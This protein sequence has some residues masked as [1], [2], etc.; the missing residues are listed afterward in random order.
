MYVLTFYMCVTIHSV[1]VTSKNP[2]EFWF[3]L[4]NSPSVMNFYLPALR[5]LTDLAVN[6]K[7]CLNS[8]ICAIYHINI[9]FSKYCIPLSFSVILRRWYIRKEQHQWK[10]NI[11]IPSVTF[12]IRSSYL[13]RPTSMYS[14]KASASL[15]FSFFCTSWLIFSQYWSCQRHSG[16]RTVQWEMDSSSNFWA[17]LHYPSFYL[18]SALRSCSPLTISLRIPNCG[19]STH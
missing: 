4:Q 10:T 12:C 2:I 7:S 1:P 18:S 15:V 8:N 6:A 16:S 13:R 14:K 3:D 19:S 9:Q 11:L 17:P 5:F